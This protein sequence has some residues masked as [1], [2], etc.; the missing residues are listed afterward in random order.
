MT[1]EEKDR[2]SN[3]RGMAQPNPL[4][5]G[6]QGVPAFPQSLSSDRPLSFTN[7]ASGGLANEGYNFRQP[8]RNNLSLPSQTS[9]PIQG[10][11]LSGGISGMTAYTSSLG[12]SGGA[13]GSGEMGSRDF[14]SLGLSQ[15]QS[16]SL[17]QPFSFKNNAS[18]GLANE[19][20]NFRLP[21]RNNF[22]L[23]LQTSIP[24]D[25]GPLSVGINRAQTAGQMGRI[26]MQNPY[27]T[28]FATEQQQANMNAQRSPDQQSSRTPEQQ[29][30]LLAQMRTKGAAIGQDIMKRNE[31]VFTAKRAE[32]NLVDELVNEARKSGYRKEDAKEMAQP[33]YKAQPSSIAGIQRDFANYQGA[34]VNKMTGFVQD[35]IRDMFP[36]N[37]G[38]SP[39]FGS[40]ASVLP[41]G[42]GSALTNITAAQGV[43]FNPSPYEAIP[44]PSRTRVVGGRIGA[45][46]FGTRAG[47]DTP[48][49]YPSGDEGRAKRAA[50]RNQR[51][52]I[53]YSSSGYNPIIPPELQG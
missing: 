12:L 45:S 49:P 4:G 44:M 16:L 14:R 31:E 30:A 21:S 41:A 24:I 52:G 51:Q 34:G 20:Y 27:G 43:Y 50:R 42:G 53:G 6:A 7:N 40:G 3:Q 35:N 9:M 15:P 5:L 13:F 46:D 47:M 33:Y 10:G 22:A 11:P 1:K 48:S 23:P 19:G 36:S 26:A 25:G 37:M 28:I 38:T 32:R 39:A 17:D 8:S 2:I 29:Q 18:G